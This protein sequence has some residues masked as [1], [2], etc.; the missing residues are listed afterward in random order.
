M[1][2][3][4]YI[5]DLP[6]PFAFTVNANLEISGKSIRT[7]YNGLS[8]LKL[9]PEVQATIRAGNLPVSQ[10]YLLSG[11]TSP[12]PLAKPMEPPPLARARGFQPETGRIV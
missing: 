8:L 7:L 3:F 9:P 4:Y 11:L 2:A 12:P 5:E 1:F 6:E 10:G